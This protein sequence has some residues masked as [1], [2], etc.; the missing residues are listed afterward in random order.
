[1]R[2]GRAIQ[3]EEAQCPTAESRYDEVP[4]YPA[5]TSLLRPRQHRAVA[6]RLRRADPVASR[7]ESLAQLRFARVYDLSGRDRGTEPQGGELVLK[8]DTGRAFEMS[9][10][11]TASLSL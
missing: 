11:E 3:S 7:E 10:G 9:A 4:T 8:A 2:L 6:A 5:G 1:M